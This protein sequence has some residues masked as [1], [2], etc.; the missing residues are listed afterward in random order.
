MIDYNDLKIDL[1]DKLKIQILENPAVVKLKPEAKGLGSD[2][3]YEIILRDEIKNSVEITLKS[4]KLLFSL[5][6]SVTDK[7][8]IKANIRLFKST[9]EEDKSENASIFSDKS[10]VILSFQDN[11]LNLIDNEKELLFILGHEL[12]HYL[13]SH[14]SNHSINLKINIL[15]LLN[16][17][18][19]EALIDLYYLYSQ[20]CELNADRIGLIACG[21]FAASAK[22]SLKLVAGQI[23]KFGEY[24]IDSFLNQSADL[25]KNGDYFVEDDLISTHPLGLFRVKALKLFN[26][27]YYNSIGDIKDIDKHL[28]EILPIELYEDKYK[29]KL[30]KGIDRPNVSKAIS[31]K[32]SENIEYEKDVFKIVAV[33]KVITGDLKMTKA[34]ASFLQNMDRDE[35]C[36]EKAMEYIEIPTMQTMKKDFTQLCDLIKKGTDNRYKSN[37]IRVMIKAA[38]VDRKITKI[39]INKIIEI[40]K[41]IDAYELG[42]QQIRN[43]Y[44]DRFD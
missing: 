20:V 25:V 27:A 5:M 37:V 32:S 24:D 2:K 41:I 12:G 23:D 14:A 30:L 28:Y 16:N 36:I 15:E 40:S 6:G 26:D 17:N 4:H 38:R 34:E 3:Y 29:V 18:K 10:N 39:E 35:K 31:S 1:E 21:D 7:F 19:N 33:I 43:T 42:I 8:D 44:G 9:S 13:F 22:A 11:I